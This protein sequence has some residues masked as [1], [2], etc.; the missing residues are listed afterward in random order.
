MLVLSHRVSDRIALLHSLNRERVAS[1]GEGLAKSLSETLE[2]ALGKCLSL[3]DPRAE[4]RG[5]EG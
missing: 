3:M 2:K 5:E 1:Q 4:Q